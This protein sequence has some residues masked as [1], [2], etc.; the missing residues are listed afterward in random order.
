MTTESASHEL[1][2]R[3]HCWN[4]TAE[5][6][7]KLLR[8]QFLVLFCTKFENKCLPCTKRRSFLLF[9]YL[10]TTDVS[11]VART[12]QHWRQICQIHDD[13]DRIGS[14]IYSF[15]LLR[16]QEQRTQLPGKATKKAR[17]K[18]WVV[19]ICKGFPGLSLVFCCFSFLRWEL[20]LN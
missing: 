13:S 1:S 15:L 12:L 20:N 7:K 8:E 10:S 18:I 3:R 19:I 11:Q 2:E 9:C 6:D 4:G 17:S 14:K 5:K 16:I